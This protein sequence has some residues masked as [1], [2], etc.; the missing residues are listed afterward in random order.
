MSRDISV[1]LATCY[2]LDG[3]GIESQVIPVAE[4]SNGK[5]THTAGRLVAAGSLSV[6]ILRR[7][8]AADRLLGLR[9]RI[10]PG[11]WIFVLCVL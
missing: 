2:E 6:F 7:G 5:N 3:P 8:S 11:A 4:R 10:P 1:G 9:F